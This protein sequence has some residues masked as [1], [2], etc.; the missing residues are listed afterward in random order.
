MNRLMTWL[1]AGV[2]L[3]LV[4]ALQIGSC[5]GGSPA[6]DSAV[7]ERA[8]GQEPESMDPQRA[9]TTQAFAVLR[10]LFEGLVTYSADGELER[11][12][13][14]A[15]DLSPD[16]LR[17]TFTIRPEL[18]WSNGDPLTAGDF[19]FSLRRL[20]TPETAAPN[21]ATLQA[22]INAPEIIAGELPPSELGVS[23]PDPQ[24]LVIEL[25]RPVPYFLSLLTL[26][27]AF[28]VH[29]ASIEQ[30]GERFD[31]PGVLVSNGAYR[32]NDWVLGSVIDL[33]AN[34]Q[35]RDADNVAI[36]RVRHHAIQEP[37][38]ELN[39]YRAGELD[40]TSTV[41]TADFANLTST[42]GSQLRIAPT[43]TVYFYGF[44]LND[45]VLADNPDLREALSLAVDR[46]RLVTQVVGRGELPA[47]S[48]VPPGVLNY[49]SPTLPFA[50][51]DRDARHELAR[52][53]YAAAGFDADNP[54]K[55]TLRY[56][57]S[58]THRRI[59]VAI[60]D[61]W[62]EVLDLEVELINEEFRVLVA[63]V[64][65]M[66]VTQIFRL[67][68]SGEYN[69]AKAFLEIFESN[70]PSNYYGFESAAYDRL[71]G[72]AENQLD[73]DRRRLHLEEAE[74]E[75]L[76]NHVVIPIY[77]T[78]SKHLV[79]PYVRGWQDN[80]LDYHYSRHL[81]LDARQP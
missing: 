16:G 12:V 37:S 75:V 55:L 5:G 29:E 61:M 27:A 52:R 15:W 11:G 59:A 62:R 67:G 51:M 78:V 26:P 72:Q 24:T 53:R 20:M 63:N 34:E 42:F 64:Q 40:V 2:L 79:K 13:A 77:F 38:V 14:E 25:S 8:I 1:G 19:V 32:L 66:Q 23:A 73:L 30:H 69:D 39:R 41:P 48:F 4:I 71:M 33:L 43:L 60:Q 68:W 54:P 21:A 17:Y 76:G 65:A 49:E 36:R 80:V 22:I 57:T 58:D 10:D 50:G 3:A 70:N 46:E 9:R 56:N 7:L 31:R 35:Y 81:S 47:Y 28:P 6:N 44:S 74:R 18:A 45:P